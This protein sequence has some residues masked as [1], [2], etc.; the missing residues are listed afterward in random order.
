MMFLKFVVS[1][2]GPKVLFPWDYIGKGME[3]K[4]YRKN[5]FA[6]KYYHRYSYCSRLS[7]EETQLLENIS[8]N[9]ILLPRDTLYTCF[10]KFKGYTTHYIQ[11]LGFIHYMGLPA[12][13]IVQDFH[14]LNR[15]CEILGKKSILI[16][17]LMPKDERVRNYSFNHGLY[18]VDPGKYH[19]D[20][21]LSAKEAIIENKKVLKDFYITELLVN[22]L[23][24]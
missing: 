6:Y 18:F 23:T 13:L 22:M 14:L 20:F 10:G 11:N 8:T 1:K 2:D 9:R 5:D 4:V 7:L 15:D 24:K 3:G 16:Y 19:K 12:D 17:D 21:S